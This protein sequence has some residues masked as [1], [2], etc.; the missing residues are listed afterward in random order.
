MVKK[1][2]EDFPMFNFENEMEL[3]GLSEIDYSDFK[4]NEAENFSQYDEKMLQKIYILQEKTLVNMKEIG[5]ANP[6]VLADAMTNL[7]FN[8]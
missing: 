8:L 4:E 2:R 7:V 1:E 6:E 3:L 5:L